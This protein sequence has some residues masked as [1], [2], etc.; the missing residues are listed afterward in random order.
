MKIFFPRNI[1]L[2]LTKILTK[3][4]WVKGMQV[5]SNEVPLHFAKGDSNYEAKI[6]C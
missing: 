3:R 1:G 2:I 5:H 6:L 4:S